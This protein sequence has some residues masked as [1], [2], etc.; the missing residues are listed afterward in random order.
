MHTTVYVL[1]EANKSPILSNVCQYFRFVTLRAVLLERTIPTDQSGN[2]NGETR[3][4]FTN[5]KVYVYIYMCTY[6]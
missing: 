3:F 4:C 2:N 1:L 5:V 6:I